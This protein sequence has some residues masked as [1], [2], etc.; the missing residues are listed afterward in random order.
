MVFGSLGKKVTKPCRSS[1]STA[2]VSRPVSART[3]CQRGAVSEAD[4]SADMR[5]CEIVDGRAQTFLEL[6]LRRPAQPGAGER[7]VRAALT[8]VVRRQRPVGDLRLR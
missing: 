4:A 1:C 7:D 6:D 2:N 3:R 5:A 8:R